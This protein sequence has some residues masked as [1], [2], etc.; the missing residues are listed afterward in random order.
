[1][2][3]LRRH[4]DALTQR[5]M[6]MNRLADIHRIRT[7][8]NRLRH[9]ANHVASVRVDDAAAKDLAVGRTA[10]CLQ[11][12]NAVGTLH[13]IIKHSEKYFIRYTI[14]VVSNQK[15]SAIFYRS[16]G[17]NEPVREWLKR[18]DKSDRQTIGEDIA[19]VQYKW[20][21]GKPR[22]DHLRGPVWE[23]RSKIG[24]RI[25]RV[26]FAVEQSEMILL[27]A[28]VKKTQQTNP[29]DIDLAT[30]RLKEW[31]NGQNE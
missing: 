24:N 14:L 11:N 3:H 19:Y 27:H 9:C 31:K 8:L 15:L 29:T 16:A 23:I 22:V 7:H 4:A 18:L 17:G 13:E 26:L 12:E 30:Q 28:F 25:A 21:I 20:P 2:R 10:F 5:R 1:M 6:R